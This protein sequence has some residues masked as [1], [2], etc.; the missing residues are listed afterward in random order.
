MFSSLQIALRLINWEVIYTFNNPKPRK[1][2]DEGSVATW[3][4]QGALRSTTQHRNMQKH[5]VLGEEQSLEVHDRSCAGDMLICTH[6][7]A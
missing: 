6:T 5:S 2:G 4:L 1:H 7:H 3:T